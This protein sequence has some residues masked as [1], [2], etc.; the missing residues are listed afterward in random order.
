MSRKCA[1]TCQAVHPWERR[2]LARNTGLKCERRAVS[3]GYKEMLA[4]SKARRK[5]PIA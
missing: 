3:K 5:E 2:A 1:I 4:K